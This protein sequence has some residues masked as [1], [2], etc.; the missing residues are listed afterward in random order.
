MVALSAVSELLRG[1]AAYPSGRPYALVV[2]GLL[3]AVVVGGVV[4]LWLV[5]PPEST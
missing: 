5:R 3:C 2:L 4:A 1:L